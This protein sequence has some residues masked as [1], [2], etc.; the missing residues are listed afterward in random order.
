MTQFAEGVYFF[1]A[2]ATTAAG[3]ATAALALTP[4]HAPQTVGQAGQ[5][6]SQLGVQDGQGSAQHAA[7]LALTRVVLS[8]QHAGN[9]A[10]P[11]VFV[12]TATAVAAPQ[13]RS[14]TSQHS[15]HPFAQSGQG[16]TQ[17][18]GVAFTLPLQHDLAASGQLP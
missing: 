5:Q 8:E 18:D 3:P 6:A 4:Q 15:S 2:P 11:L 16:V 12:E 9:P 13:H 1:T 14:Q 7:F 10:L 17:H